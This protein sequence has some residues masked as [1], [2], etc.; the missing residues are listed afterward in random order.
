MNWAKIGYLNTNSS[1]DNIGILI[2]NYIEEKPLPS[3]FSMNVSIKGSPKD[4][5]D[6]TKTFYPNVY[7]ITETN[8]IPILNIK[9]RDPSI[10]ILKRKPIIFLIKDTEIDSKKSYLIEFSS[11]T[12]KASWTIVPNNE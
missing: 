10:Y 4:D 1:Q 7:M 8:I 5:Q 11:S 2:L 12:S 6:G 9:Y 3:S